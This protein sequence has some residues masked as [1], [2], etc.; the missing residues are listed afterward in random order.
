MRRAAEKKHYTV[1][2]TLP[3]LLIAFL[4]GPSVNF[5]TDKREGEVLEVKWNLGKGDK[6]YFNVYFLCS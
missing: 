5:S 4:K 2:P 3:A 6:R 1:T